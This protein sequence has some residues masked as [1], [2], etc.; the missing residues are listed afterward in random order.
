[1]TLVKFLQSRLNMELD[2]QSLFGLHVYSCT[3]WLRPCNSPPS[4]PRIWAHI[5]GRNWSAKVDDISLKPPGHGTESSHRAHSGVPSNDTCT[6]PC[7]EHTL[8]N[9]SM[10]CLVL[11]VVHG[12]VVIYGTVP[13]I[14]QLCSHRRIFRLKKYTGTKVQN[15]EK[16]RQR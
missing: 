13:T 11:P 14:K 4:S 10:F 2:I 12:W 7:V 9:N 8:S 1:M 6:C 15:V 5:R 3:H 16:K